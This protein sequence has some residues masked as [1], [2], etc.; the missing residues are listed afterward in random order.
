MYVKQ[1]GW[2][3]ESCPLCKTQVHGQATA[4]ETISF[5]E[6]NTLGRQAKMNDERKKKKK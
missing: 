3:E 4:E 2:E 1:R 5:Q 6:E